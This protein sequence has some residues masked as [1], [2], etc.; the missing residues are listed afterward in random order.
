MLPLET[1]WNEQPS[2]LTL[3]TSAVAGFRTTTESNLWIA[4]CVVFVMS[5][6][7]VQFVKHLQRHPQI[8]V[9][10]CVGYLK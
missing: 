4:L 1:I 10:R 2:Q 6:I 5:S 3:N 8:Y 9:A 7:I